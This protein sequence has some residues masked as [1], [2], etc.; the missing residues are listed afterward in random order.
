MHKNADATHRRWHVN[1]IPIEPPGVDDE[2]YCSVVVENDKE[3]DDRLF[4]DP[5]MNHTDENFLESMKKCSSLV[6]HA[7]LEGLGDDG[8]ELKGVVK[9]WIESQEGSNGSARRVCP[10]P[11]YTKCRNGELEVRWRSCKNVSRTVARRAVHF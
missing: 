2:R 8:P 1:G 4:V 3:G 5:V 7:P 9:Q 10:N 11:P 6:H